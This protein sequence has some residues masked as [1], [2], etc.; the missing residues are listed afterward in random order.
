MATVEQCEQAFRDLAD[1]LATDDA[2]SHKSASFDR[3]LSCVLTDLDLIFGGQLK[4]GQLVEIRRVADPAAQIRLAMTSDELL[5][6]VDGKLNLVSAWASG[7]IKIQ[8]S[9]V[10]LI[11]LRTIF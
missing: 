5:E 4:G 9:V 10:D 7:R 8:A 1:R 2:A 6:L 11:K 3:T